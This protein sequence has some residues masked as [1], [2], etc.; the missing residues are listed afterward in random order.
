MGEPRDRDQLVD[1][2][3][4]AKQR[5]IVDADALAMMEGVLLFS[6]MRV[7]DIM[8]PRSQMVTI[9]EEDSLDVIFATVTQHGHSRFPVLSD[10]RQD[11][12]GILHA[13]DLLNY[14]PKQPEAFDLSDIIRP[15][16]VVPQ[17]KRLD[18]LLNDFRQNRNH[19]AIVVDEYGSVA[20]FVTIEDVLEQIVGDIADEFDIDEDAFVKTHPDGRY[21]I[22]A[23]MPVK[24]FNEYFDEE[25]S[26][27]EFDTIGGWVTHTFGYVPKRGES[28]R[29]GR[30]QF[31]VL[32]G[33]NRR[34]SLLQA[35]M[36]E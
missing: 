26:T 36:V 16:V 3:R 28:I 21:I 10:H 1:V 31:T 32:N 35:R 9:N 23:H 13:K 5:E 25:V 34:I 20:G 18:T 27:G 24:D 12:I 7:R 29:L 15:A 33:N 11:I 4:D 14:D 30:Y 17:S 6:Q 19:M 22:K 2:L 8:I